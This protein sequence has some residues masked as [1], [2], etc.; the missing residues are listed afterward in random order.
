M[1]V[2]MP[3]G[4]PVRNT[5]RI[6]SANSW[7]I[8]WPT[9]QG[10][11]GGLNLLNPGGAN[12]YD[13]EIDLIEPVYWACTTLAPAG[14]LGSLGS[15]SPFGVLKGTSQIIKAI[16]TNAGYS[17][18]DTNTALTRVAQLGGFWLLWDGSTTPIL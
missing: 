1:G 8:L 6:D 14:A 12:P 2:R 15:P 3:F 16:S 18:M 9:W 13:S 10:I 7:H 4:V 17:A 5:P 11:T